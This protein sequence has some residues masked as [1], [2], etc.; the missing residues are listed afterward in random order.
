[1]YT[2]DTYN[3]IV[4]NDYI[5]KS[6]YLMLESVH[7]YD[8]I[9][10]RSEVILEAVLSKENINKAI[11]RIIEAVDEARRKFRSVTR[12]LQ[13]KNE[14]WLYTA[15]NHDINADDLS[16]FKAEIFPYWN[17]IPRIFNGLNIPEYNTNYSSLY[18]D[19]KQFMEKH[20][21][22][23]LDQDG[24]INKNILRG[25]TN[26]SS[27]EKMVI[28]GD[29][30]KSTYNQVVK[31]IDSIYDL[32][33]KVSSDMNKISRTL[34]NIR[35]MN[36]PIDTNESVMLSR[37]IFK[38]EYFDILLEDATT[39]DDIEKSQNNN[40]NNKKDVNINPEQNEKA[41]EADNAYKSAIQWSKLCSSVTTAE[42]DILDE[43]YG[44]CSKFVDKVISK[45]K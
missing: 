37:S 9:N 4:E 25:I 45:G 42:M 40:D 41:K 29:R 12:E 11:D 32:R 43:A 31:T 22:E 1:M 36:R 16:N 10:N 6:N 13:R 39:P 38:D 7:P 35:S 18:N 26:S 21:K 3:T 19:E 33:G 20:F 5:I 23:I 44:A 27:E 28:E 34:K 17:A 15:K 8:L 24:N 30:A 2:L 14:E